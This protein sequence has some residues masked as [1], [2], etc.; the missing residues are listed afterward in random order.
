MGYSYLQVKQL[1]AIFGEN[2]V[3]FDYNASKNMAAN[4]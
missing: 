3:F 4:I 1:S 2:I